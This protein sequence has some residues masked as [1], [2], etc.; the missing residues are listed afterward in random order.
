MRR[1]LIALLLLCVLAILIK[2]WL[3]TFGPD[4]NLNPI[5]AQPGLVHLDCPLHDCMPGV[6]LIMIQGKD[7]NLYGECVATLIDDNHI[8]TASHCLD[9]DD[10]KGFFFFQWQDKTE[11]RQLKSVV[12]HAERAPSGRIYNIDWAILELSRPIEGIEPH[13][14][15]RHPPE[16]LDRVFFI[17]KTRNLNLVGFSLAK[18]A[19]K[20]YEHQ[21]IF[22]NHELNERMLLA[23]G[24][25][26]LQMGDSGA[27]AFV[28]GNGEIQALL[29]GYADVDS[30]NFKNYILQNGPESAPNIKGSF[31]MVN[32]LYCM[33]I[34]GQ[35]APKTLCEK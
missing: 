21:T 16:K 35:P 9:S 33:N 34:A 4:R 14:I 28:E 2:S 31:G 27:P 12:A 13:P 17:T 19:C 29:S 25:C 10:P 30:E 24:G 3:T 26:A 7:L 23:V 15:A 8:I 22:K 11:F 1:Y 20:T 18:T 5:N 6:G 32:R